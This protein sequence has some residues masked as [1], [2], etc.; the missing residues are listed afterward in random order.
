[1]GARQFRWGGL[2][3][4]SVGR[5]DDRCPGPIGHA[6]RTVHANF[7]LCNILNGPCR[8]TPRMTEAEGYDEPPGAIY[9]DLKTIL[10][11]NN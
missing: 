6:T 4:L 10:G 7:R 1:M 8:P 11:K 9:N 5:S 2:N 3:D